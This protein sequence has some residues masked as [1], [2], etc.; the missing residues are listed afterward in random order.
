MLLVVVPLYSAENLSIP[1]IYSEEGPGFKLGVAWLIMGCMVSHF[2][3]ASL[4]MLWSMHVLLRA[5]GVCLLL[6]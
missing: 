5:F 1:L 2:C 3:T 4:Q 6:A